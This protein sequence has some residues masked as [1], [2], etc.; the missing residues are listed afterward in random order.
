MHVTTRSDAEPRRA[1]LQNTLVDRVQAQL[2]VLRHREL[3]R[4]LGPC[5]R[6]GKPVRAQQNAIRDNGRLTH[7]HCHITAP[8]RRPTAL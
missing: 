2:A 1:P 3:G 8:T 7:L 4:E 5:M 6:C